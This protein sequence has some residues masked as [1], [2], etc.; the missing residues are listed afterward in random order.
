[1][2]IIIIIIIK[3]VHEVQHKTNKNIRQNDIC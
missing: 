1:M 2:I 3:I